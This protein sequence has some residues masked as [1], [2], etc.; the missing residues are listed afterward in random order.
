MIHASDL[1]GYFLCGPDVD[2]LGV[3]GNTM[4]VDLR[5]VGDLTTAS[6]ESHGDH[7]HPVIGQLTPVSQ[8]LLGNVAEPT[9]V[10]EYRLRRYRV[11]ELAELAV[12]ELDGIAVFTKEHLGHP[13]RLCQVGMRSQMSRVYTLS[14]RG[15]FL[16]LD[17]PLRPGRR[18][19]LEVPM[20]GAV[21]P[22]ASGRVTFV[23][24]VNAPAHPDLPAGVALRFDRVDAIAACAI[25]HLV[26]R[27]LSA[28]EIR[29]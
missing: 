16:L 7:D 2:L 18:V 15:A 19:D 4:A 1:L 8:S 24:R 10:H 27:R 3:V 20:G 17:R 22:C 11:G 21:H 26:E 29:N 13:H 23:N 14:S 9:A 5:P 6:L 28:L 12:A 25:D